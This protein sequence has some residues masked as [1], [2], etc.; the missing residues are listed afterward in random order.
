MNN[1][2]RE[3][4]TSTCEEFVSINRQRKESGTDLRSRET[5]FS[6]AGIMLSLALAMRVLSTLIDSPSNFVSRSDILL[7]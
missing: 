5:V 2:T 6:V 3:I 4:C 7:K 1:S